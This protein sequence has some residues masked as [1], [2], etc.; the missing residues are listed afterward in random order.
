M[1]VM[2]HNNIW[3]E[4]HATHP[5][6]NSIYNYYKDYKFGERVGFFHF[7]FGKIFVVNNIFYMLIW[8]DAYNL[9]I[10]N[11]KLR[12]LKLINWMVVFIWFKPGVWLVIFLF[13]NKIILIPWLCCNYTVL[14]PLDLV[15]KSCWLEAGPWTNIYGIQHR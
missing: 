1:N 14:Y 3:Y 2:K 13:A 8:M 6:R 15:P 7:E 10:N 4:V 12:E 9:S 11:W 5:V